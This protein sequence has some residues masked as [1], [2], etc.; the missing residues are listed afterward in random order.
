LNKNGFFSTLGD[1]YPF[2]IGIV[3]ALPVTGVPNKSF[4]VTLPKFK[5]TMVNHRL[6]GE[7]FEQASMREE[8]W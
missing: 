7:N 2:D 6:P 3:Y 8:K 4:L 1:N 5:L